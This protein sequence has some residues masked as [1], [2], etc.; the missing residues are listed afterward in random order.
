MGMLQMVYFTCSY[1]SVTV[2]GVFTKFKDDNV[3]TLSIN[4]LSDTQKKKFRTF[5]DLHLKD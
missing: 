5:W 1:R 4:M 3:G 2:K